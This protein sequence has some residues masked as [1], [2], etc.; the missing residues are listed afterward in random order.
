MKSQLIG[1]N[2]QVNRNFM[3][4][5]VKIIYMKKIGEKVKEARSCSGD[6][7]VVKNN[8]M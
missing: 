2:S 1:T 8:Q 7:E 4:K 3:N 5:Y 6:K